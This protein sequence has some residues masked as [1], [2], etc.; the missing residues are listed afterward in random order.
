MSLKV[1]CLA[2]FF[3]HCL[4]TTS[5]HTHVHHYPLFKSET[6]TGLWTTTLHV[7]NIYNS[8]LNTM[9]LHTIIEALL[10]LPKEVNR[11]VKNYF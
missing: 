10:L 4:T 1:C 2:S 5:V 9:S 11:K 6:K 8:K 7:E 3:H